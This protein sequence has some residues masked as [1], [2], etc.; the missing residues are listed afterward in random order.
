ML[1]EA[2]RGADVACHLMDATA[3]KGESDDLV[4]ITVGLKPLPEFTID[5]SGEGGA[6]SGGDAQPAVE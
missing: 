3:R 5:A 2:L 6:T 1:R 4:R